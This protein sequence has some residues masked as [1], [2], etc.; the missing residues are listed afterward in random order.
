MRLAEPARVLGA[1]RARASEGDRQDRNAGANREVERAVLERQQVAI[2][3]PRSL[4]N[5][6]TEMPPRSAR[7]HSSRQARTL[8]PSPRRSGM[9]PPSRIAQPLSGCLN[10]SS[11]ATQRMSHGKNDRRNGS[12]CDSWFATTTYAWVSMSGGRS[13]SMSNFHS[14]DSR[15]AVRPSRRNHWP[16]TRWVGSPRWRNDDSAMI[17]KNEPITAPN[18][19]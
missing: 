15:V 12:A 18:S 19:A 7:S 4:G 10:R 3:R 17:G 14:V 11:L 9:S 2:R 8:S 1:H 5:I 6:I 16:G 13:P